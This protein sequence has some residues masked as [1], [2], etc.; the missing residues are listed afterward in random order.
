MSAGLPA[1]IV[2]AVAS[3]LDFLGR[4]HLSHVCSLWRGALLED[5]F[6]WSHI[7]V[8]LR[9]PK[10]QGTST[11]KLSQ[12]SGLRT[13]PLL[14]EDLLH[15]LTRTG[16]VPVRIGPLRIPNSEK[17]GWALARVIVT[18][19]HRITELDL[20]CAS[21]R[22]SNIVL[23]V[24]SDNRDRTA[25]L[26]KR[27]AFANAADDLVNSRTRNPEMNLEQ[28]L[29]VARVEVV[30]PD[31]IFAGGAPKLTTLELENVHLAS[32]EP[33]YSALVSVVRF[34]VAGAETPQRP[35]SVPVLLGRVMPRLTHL[36]TSIEAN[37]VQYSLAHSQ[38]IQTLCILCPEWAI[39][40]DQWQTLSTILVHQEVLNVELV[41][42]SDKL[43]LLEF[44]RDLGGWEHTLT[45]FHFV[46][47]PSRTWR[48]DTCRT[49]AEHASRR[50]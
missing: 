39:Q 4:V 47:N 44:A 28:R 1:E 11:S 23:K 35:A 10:K 36:R 12:L 40:P 20:Q 42:C 43:L 30:L 31:G 33:K 16:D 9:I 50:D 7:A 37:G 32:P 26:L 13:R 38:A 14:A 49:L 45:S 5:A 34:G 15:L 2:C 24:L 21:A 18:H 46:C 19:L 27:F 8:S 22:T 25:P 41:S 3:H 48:H 6:L 29:A 17:E